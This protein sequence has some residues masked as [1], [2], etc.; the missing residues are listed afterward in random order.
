MKKT[1]AGL[2]MYRMKN[3][4]LEVLLVHPGGPYWKNKDEGAWSIP[5]GEA[6]NNETGNALLEVAR[7]EFEEETGIKPIGDFKYLTSVNRKDGKVVEAW[8]FEGDCDPTQLKS[9][10][11][12]INWPPRSGRQIEIPEIDRGAFFNIEQ[13]KIKIGYQLPFIN[14]F[15]QWCKNRQ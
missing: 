8:M 7:R 6:E 11:I 1:S 14:E 3:E 12:M 15:E 4:T 10:T 13:A 2:L 5:K 9:N